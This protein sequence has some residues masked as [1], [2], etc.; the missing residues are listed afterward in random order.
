M[1]AVSAI[2]IAEILSD[3]GR[4]VEAQ[5]LLSDALA[6]WRASGAPTSIAFARS[7]LG[8]VAARAGR[9]D[10]ALALYAQAREA[11]VGVLAVV[12]QKRQIDVAVSNSGAAP[13]LGPRAPD[14]LEPENLVIELL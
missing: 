1:A 6:V 10:E 14:H 12:L 7:Y 4:L 11:F 13:V 9:H 2:N 8:R 5:P 3:Q